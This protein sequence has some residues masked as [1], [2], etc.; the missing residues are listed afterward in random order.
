LCV[1]WSEHEP[2]IEVESC[3]QLNSTLDL[4]ASRCRE[5]CPT[6][7][8][9]DVHEHQIGIGLGLPESFVHIEL[10]SGDPPYMVTVGD[11]EVDGG[12]DFYLHNYHH[13]EIPRRNLIPTTQAKVVVEEFVRSGRRSADV[14]W[15]EV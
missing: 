10:E 13:T 5:G 4:I 14:Q 11:S 8:T 7:A 2:S 6:I 15:E 12:V 1:V 9:I 3:E